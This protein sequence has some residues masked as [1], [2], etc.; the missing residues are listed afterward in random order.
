MYLTRSDEEMSR[1]VSAPVLRAQIDMQSFETVPP[2]SKSTPVI[3]LKSAS[4]QPL[5]LTVDK[6]ASDLQNGMH[7]VINGHAC[8]CNR[9]S[10][11]H[12]GGFAQVN[13]RASDIFTN[14]HFDASYA[15]SQIV[16]VPVVRRRE[17]RCIALDSAT[18]IAILRSRN[19]EIREDLLLPAFVHSTESAATARTQCEESI[20]R[21][22][23]FSVVVLSAVGKEEIISTCDDRGN[24]GLLRWVAK[25]KVRAQRIIARRRLRQSEPQRR[26]SIELGDRAAVSA[27]V[28]PTASVYS[29]ATSGV[30][31]SIQSGY[32]LE[33]TASVFQSEQMSPQGSFD[34]SGSIGPAR[35]QMM[36]LRSWPM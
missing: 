25:L 26:N 11:G 6:K 21:G 29:G 18:G 28:G 32:S 33:P 22:K 9:V 35:S 10:F 3:A 36:P 31:G 15:L 7:L 16:E 17:Y 24:I 1:A 4:D 30:G 13:I 23:F 14:E 34:S 19:G 2:L 20:S 5:R 27:T 8:K 12:S